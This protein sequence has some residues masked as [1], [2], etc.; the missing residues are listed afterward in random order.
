MQSVSI[1]GQPFEGLSYSFLDFGQPFNRFSVRFPM[2]SPISR[3]FSVKL[4]EPQKAEICLECILQ[5][6]NHMEITMYTNQTQICAI[7]RI[8]HAE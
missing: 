3:C 5:M 1:F 8:P 4:R 6:T 7:V 2:E